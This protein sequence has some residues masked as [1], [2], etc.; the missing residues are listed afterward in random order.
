MKGKM[1]FL[2]IKEICIYVHDLEKTRGFYHG[3]LGLE[4]ILSVEGKHIF[5]RAGSSVLLCFISDY[6]KTQTSTP[7]HGASGNIHFALEVN[8]DEYAAVKNEILQ[9][10]ISIE[11]EHEWK[12]NLLSFY[13]RDPDGHL[14]EIA[15]KGIWD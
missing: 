3:K 4:V 12:D 5:F 8:R 15:Q 10:G 1:N 7:P 2:H 9:K 14:V 13:F 6:T 11:H